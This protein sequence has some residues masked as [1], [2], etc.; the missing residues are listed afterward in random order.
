VSQVQVEGVVQGGSVQ[1][2]AFSIRERQNHS[3]SSLVFSQIKSLL[4][5]FKILPVFLRSLILCIVN[6][7]LLFLSLFHTT[8]QKGSKAII[9][10]LAGVGLVTG[11]QFCVILNRFFSDIL[12][13]QIAL[14]IIIIV[15][16]A[17]NTVK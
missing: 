17:E 13:Y 12:S 6:L 7:S 10:I 9:C 3:C 5:D 14:A 16:I 1:D 2:V 8:H 11:V 15:N 4:C